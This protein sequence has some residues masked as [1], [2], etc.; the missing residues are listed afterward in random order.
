[1]QLELQYSATGMLSGEPIRGETLFVPSV[2]GLLQKFEKLTERRSVVMSSHSIGV[3]T[4]SVMA[5]KSGSSDRKCSTAPISALILS[6]M[7][8]KTSRLNRSRSVSSV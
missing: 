5:G 4:V 1:M 3:G 2:T 8:V 7:L 6:S